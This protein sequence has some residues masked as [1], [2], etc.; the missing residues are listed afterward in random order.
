MT[1]SMADIDFP[2]LTTAERDR[3]L[4]L[5]RELMDELGLDALL[6]SGM[7]RDQLD[8]YITNEGTRGLCLLPRAGEPVTMVASGNVTLGR[9]DV[10]G[11]AYERWVPDQRLTSRSYG[12][13]DVI[14]ELGL[15]RA[16][17][18]VVGLTS[19]APA[20]AAGTIPYNT[21][22]RILDALPEAE[23]VDV[24]G[25]Y[26]TVMLV[27]GPEE[28]A[29]IR[30]SA[31]IG[32]HACAAMIEAAGAG[33][34]EC[35]IVA[36]GMHEVTRRGGMWLTGP[37]RSGPERLGWAGADWIWMGGGSRVLEKGDAFGA[38][39]FTFYGGFES[40][41]QIDISIGEPDADHRFLHEVTE[42][43]Y[44][45]GLDALRPGV[46]FAELCAAMEAP[47]RAAGCWNM[48]PLVQTVS[49]VIFNS[50]THVGLGTQPGLAGLPLP[51]ETPRDGDFLIV[52]GVAFAFEPNACRDRKRVCLGGTVLVTEDGHEELNS[53]C[54]R[55]NV[56]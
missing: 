3:R 33:V 14:A 19:R 54:N 28:L 56:V 44:R 11:R 4:R 30:K 15:A 40:Q 17:I 29:M 26:E 36:A 12:P 46:T 51:D 25:R 1:G 10:P 27:H 21:W 52:P 50:A 45:A 9:H 47:L 35:E 8:R 16:R 39:L 48:G 37:Q 53:L 41:Q 38:E 42:A 43:S 7:G 34:R 31:Q 2:T 6:V 5:L 20:S 24:A 55:L 23:F 32:E 13:A 18:G 49:P 22:K